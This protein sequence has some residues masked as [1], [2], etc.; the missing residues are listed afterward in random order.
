MAFVQ[1]DPKQIP[2]NAFQLVGT[3]W[4]LITAGD[5]QK[6][7]TMTASWGGFGV[8]WNKPVSFIFV[9]PQRYT[10]TFIEREGCYSLCFFAG[11]FRKQLSYLGTISGRDEDK[12]KTAGLTTVFADGVPYFEEA[13]M[14]LLCKTLYR[15]DLV[16][17]GF[18]DRALDEKN[19]PE[20][21]HHRAYVGE[22]LKVLRKA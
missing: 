20:Q 15:Q 16:P 21:D 18:V 4:M 6:C 10:R 13:Q 1:L 3:D 2:E 22:V 17:E 11:G 19:Y 14:V 12:I 8:L 9:R 5:G 7:N